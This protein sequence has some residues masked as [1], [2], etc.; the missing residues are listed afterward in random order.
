MISFILAVACIGCDVSKT[1]AFETQAQL[2][3]V[4]EE[5][6]ETVAHATIDSPATISGVLMTPDWMFVDSAGAHHSLSD[7]MSIPESTLRVSPFDAITQKIEKLSLSGD[8]ATVTVK[9]TVAAG[10]P[11]IGDQT[12]QL[13]HFEHG[14]KQ[15]PAV[16]VPSPK[17]RTFKDTWVKD[18][19]SW[20]M[21][22][23]EEIGKPATEPAPQNVY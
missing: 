16:S 8:T 11:R 5:I 7:A 9:V 15:V 18:G 1:A 21:K 14:W 13:G 23:R 12:D 20:K 6:A 2:Q 4:Y 10:T 19:G 17:T 3:A 22:S